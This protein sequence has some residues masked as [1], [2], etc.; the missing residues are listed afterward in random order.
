VNARTWPSGIG[1]MAERIRSYREA[2]PPE[3]TS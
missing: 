3:W 2:T 1:E